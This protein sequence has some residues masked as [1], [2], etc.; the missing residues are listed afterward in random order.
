MTSKFQFVTYQ[1]KELP[2]FFG[3]STI[4]EYQDR[5]GIDLDMFDESLENLKNQYVLFFEACRNGHKKKG[6]P[7]EFSFDSFDDVFDE[8]YISFTDMLKVKLEQGEEDS[9]KNEVEAES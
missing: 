8:C 4:R 7:F 5:T 6:L 1:G 2:L 3:M 9:K